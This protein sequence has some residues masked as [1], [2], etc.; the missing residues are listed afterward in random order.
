MTTVIK[1]AGPVDLLAMMPAMVGFHPSESVVILAF[2]GRRTC[3]ALR[4][5]LPRSR[6][7]TVMKR[8]AT[9][10]VGT[11]CRLRGIDGAV[12]IV[13]TD[14]PFDGGDAP[15]R[16]FAEVMG[17]RLVTAGIGL[18]DCLVLAADGWASYL[19]A[20]PP[21]IHDRGEVEAAAAA[22]PAEVRVRHAPPPARIPPA[23]ATQRRRVAARLARYRTQSDRMR[24]ADGM[25]EPLE[26]EP[27]GDLPL[28]AES[29]L[30]LTPDEL[31]RHGSL[32]LFAV[33][34]P[35]IRDTV[36][37][38]WSSDLATGYRYWDEAELFARTKRLVPSADAERI[39]GRGARPDPDRVER[40][41]EVLR[42]IA[43]WVEGFERLPLLCMLGW[44]SWTLGRGSDAGVYLDEA[45]GIDPRYGMLEVLQALLGSGMLPEWAFEG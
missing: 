2:R 42:T 41:I 43:S 13:V 22:M 40:G 7:P 34:G 39:L 3:G 12:V 29:A 8:I 26:L 35:P 9:T 14:A 27:L 36:M 18:R 44:L 21:A 33:Q 15:H 31:L 5:D 45:A 37:V 20:A 30:H 4:F 28:F 16:D 11:V 32:L 25:L 10:I 1:A 6:N 24:A 38:Q 23:P 19:D 17:R